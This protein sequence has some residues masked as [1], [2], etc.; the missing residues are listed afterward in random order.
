MGCILI[1]LGT[2]FYFGR[3]TEAALA[4]PIVGVILLIVGIVYPNKTK[5]EGQV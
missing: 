5:V 1:F 4:L 2:V 3:G